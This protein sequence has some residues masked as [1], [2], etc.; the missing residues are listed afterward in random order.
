MSPA[1]PPL[2]VP[3]RALEPG[4]ALLEEAQ[5]RY[6]TRVHRLGVGDRLALFDPEARVEAVATI[7]EVGR[8]VRCLVEAVEPSPRI[9]ASGVTLVS[10]LGKGDKP[11]QV[12]KDATALGVDR[13]V[14]AETARSVVVGSRSGARRER[15]GT[16]AVE[17]ARQSLR[18]D[19]PDLLGPVPFAEALRRADVVHRLCLVPG[20]DTALG[21]ALR[22]RGAQETLAVVI[23][24]EGGLDDH[25][26]DAARTAGYRAVSFGTRVLRTETAV[27]AVLGAVLAYHGAK[28]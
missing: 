22:A 12:V 17:A 6:V 5:A 19:V 16:I 9:A 25:E 14:F 18:G 1:R 2:R 20:A 15:L 10:G 8:R 21:D 4:E 26:L 27:V 24:P 11:E 28:W 7:V 23:G 13:I 3:G